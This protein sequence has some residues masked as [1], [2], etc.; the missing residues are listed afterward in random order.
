MIRICF[1]GYDS[2]Q[3]TIPLAAACGVGTVGKSLY[4]LGRFHRLNAVAKTL[5]QAVDLS[6]AEIVVYPHN[7]EPSEHTRDIEEQSLVAG[8]PCLFF[9]P[10]D[11]PTPFSI[12]Y[13]KLY[14]YSLYADL[15]S[16]REHVMP[17]LCN[18]ILDECN[19]IGVAASTRPINWQRVPEIGFCGYVGTPLSRLVLRILQQREKVAGLYL[20]DR[21]LR[22]LRRSD[23][24]TSRFVT[25]TAHYG[26]V[27][28]RPPTDAQRIRIRR[29]FLEN[30]MSS[31]YAL[32]LRGKGNYSFRFYEALSAG[33]I[34]VL[35]NT[36]CVL[37][38]QDQIDWRKHVVWVEEDR[39]QSIAE[40]VSDFHHRLTAEQFEELQ[41]S[42]RN[43]WEVWFRP[44]AYYLRILRSEITAPQISSNYADIK[45]QWT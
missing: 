19:G 2:A 4:G 21:V 43:L 30:L 32:C 14:R 28:R 25:R 44:E 26:G 41:A 40:L 18:D 15:A 34:P 38:F 23:L 36:R 10:N 13:G 35:V 24:V 27:A 1:L 12:S 8:V 6:D 17:A 33:R 3:P 45:M 31:P 7:F 29:E 20:R 39:I 11:D 42:N 37:P 9:H 16:P 5:F 22:V